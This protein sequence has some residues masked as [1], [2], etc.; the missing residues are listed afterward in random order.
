MVKAASSGELRRILPMGERALLIETPG[1]S[2]VLD[3]HAA[4]V[5]AP[6]DGVIDV[7]PAARTVLVHVDP[8]VLPLASARAWIDRAL[9]GEVRSIPSGRDEEAQTGLEFLV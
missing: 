3:L 6:P 5:D 4:L 2:A 9:T 8:A 1:L 7:V